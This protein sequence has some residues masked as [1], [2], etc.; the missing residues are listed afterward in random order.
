M[1]PRNL[2]W[3]RLKEY[4]DGDKGPLII[5]IGLLEG[6]GAH[7]PI[8]TDALIASFLADELAK[9]NSWVSLPPII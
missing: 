3:T 1:Y 7:L 6:H 9:R 2:T 5:P 8:D 4:I